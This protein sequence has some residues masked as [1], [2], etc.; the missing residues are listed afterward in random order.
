MIKSEQNTCRYCGEIL[1]GRAGK[2]YCNIA[3]KNAYSNAHKSEEELGVNRI[4]RVLRSNWRILKT[5]NPKGKTTVRKEFLHE[6]GYDFNYFT[7][8]YL[9]DKKKVY[10]FCY[11]MGLT[12]VSKTHICIVNW[13]DYMERFQHPIGRFPS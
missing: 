9:T 13:Q 11:S 3:C 8:V 2:R 10:Y 12:E 5:L 1:H 6:K 4:N 7:N